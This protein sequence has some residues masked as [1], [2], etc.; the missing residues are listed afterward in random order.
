MRTKKNKVTVIV[1]AAIGIL[2]GLVTMA[3]ALYQDSIMPKLISPD[4]AA[5]VVK[6]GANVAK[7][8]KVYIDQND[9]FYR[10]NPTYII[11]ASDGRE[12]WV[13]AI[14]GKI[15]SISGK[16][17]AKP[18]DKSELPLTKEAA[19]K[20]AEDY[21]RTLYDG[22]EKLKLVEVMLNGNKKSYQ[23][24]WKQFDE[25]N[26]ELQKRVFINI[27]FTT[28]E[29]GGYV[30]KNEEATISTKPRITKE[31][32]VKTAILELQSTAEV[33]GTVLKV[34]K[35]L[36]GNERLI[37]GVEYRDDSSGEIETGYI[38]IDAITGENITDKL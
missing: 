9:R 12:Y 28:G 30:A 22:F 17:D 38:S 35:D 25:N 3:F 8:N 2:M 15:T 29:L 7:I 6:K 37:W 24:A 16:M 32:A 34:T 20:R 5:E 19:I 31:E 13:N 14:N 21:V 26:A 27:D 1:I 11:D 33:K 4:Q 10:K 23:L 18:L 36:E